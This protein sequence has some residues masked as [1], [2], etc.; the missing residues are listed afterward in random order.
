MA[1][2]LVIGAGKMGEALIAGWIASDGAPADSIAASDITAVE[3]SD[4][5][6]AY[7]VEAHGISCIAD[8]SEAE[9]ADIVVLAVKPQV[10]PQVLQTVAD[11]AALNCGAEGPLFVSIAAGVATSTIE[12]ALAAGTRVVRVMPNTP[13]MVGA[14]A[15]GVCGGACASAAEVEHVRDLFACMG[16]AVMVAEADM[17]AVCAVSG[18]GPAYVDALIEAMRDG[19]IAEGLDAALAEKLAIQ[20]VFGTA[21]LLLE[22]GMTPEDAR[23]AVCSPGGTTLAGLDAMYAAGFTDSIVKGV[24]AAAARSRELGKC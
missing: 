11:N 17:D 5:R 18:S 4:A 9:G 24:K 3:P 14:G 13:L 19:G 10:M 12:A 1:R 23:I 8:A 6:R 7:L 15:S 20:T 16:E 2:I 21:K 22:T